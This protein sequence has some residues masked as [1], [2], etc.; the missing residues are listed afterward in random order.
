VSLNLVLIPLF[1]EGFDFVRKDKLTGRYYGCNKKMATHF[2]RC[3]R[4]NPNVPF[5][6]NVKHRLR[7]ERTRPSGY[8][9]AVCAIPL[10]RRT[11]RPKANL[12]LRFPVVDSWVYRKAGTLDGKRSVLIAMSRGH[13]TPMKMRKH[14]LHLSSAKCDILY[15]DLRRANKVARK[16]QLRAQRRAAAR[17]NHC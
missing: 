7:L 11:I 6:P 12:R 5:L 16:R 15:Q 9:L 14:I 3:T 13:P 17:K 8:A 2:L 4:W 10:R 1:N